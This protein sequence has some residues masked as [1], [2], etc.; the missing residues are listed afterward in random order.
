M[1]K[2]AVIE[3]EEYWL[4]QLTS[5]LYQ[6]GESHG[7][8]I[9]VHAFRSGE[10]I[11]NRYLAGQD[12]FDIVF[13]DIELGDMN[14]LEVM[15][16]LRGAGMDSK[17]V[18][19]TNHQAMNFIQDSFALSAM[20]YYVKPVTPENI[21]DCMERTYAREV[22]IHESGGEH[23]AIP[24]KEIL[25]FES[26]RN[27]IKTHCLSPLLNPKDFRGTMAKFALALPAAFVQIHRSLVV[28]VAHIISIKD[29][30]ICMRNG[31]VLPMGKLYVDS[32]M[33]AFQG[34]G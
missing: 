7:S 13:V 1:R 4:A 5:L 9:E 10:E 32:V 28:N 11:L 12:G 30:K 3:N 16:K 19:T 6:W 21:A 14:G 18:V 33:R 8:E 23:Q 34:Q 20:Q 25:Y 22:F 15:R 24:Y 27:Y 26:D 31:A 29:H 17:I 2:V